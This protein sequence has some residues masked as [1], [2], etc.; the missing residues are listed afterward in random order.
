MLHLLDDWALW[1]ATHKKPDAG[2]IEPLPGG[3]TNQ[4]FILHLDQGDFVLRVEAGNS[5]QLDIHRDVEFRIHQI[6]ARAGLVPEVLY[7]SCDDD[8]Y[9]IRRYLTG[10]VLTP[11]DLTSEC[12]REMV[13]LLKQLHSLPVDDDIPRLSIADKAERYWSAIC[14]RGDSNAALAELMTDLQRELAPPPDNRLCLCHMDPTLNNWVR[15]AAGLQLVDWEYSACGHPFWDLVIVCQEARLSE[16]QEAVLLQAYGISSHG[17]DFKRW[18]HAK[19]QM[20]YLSGLW[21]CVQRI[22]TPRELET[23]LL[24]LRAL[25]CQ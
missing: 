17:A 10:E 9:W 15:T 5:R 7:R 24:T 21:Y 11:Q 14:E 23:Y 6:A 4:S 19:A 22:W 20:N 25:I 1:G 2:Q 12:L 18:Q 8:R 16:E 13:Q 3:L